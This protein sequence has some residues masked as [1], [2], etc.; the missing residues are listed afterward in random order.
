MGTSY[1]LARTAPLGAPVPTRRKRELER[2]VVVAEDPTLWST[3][4]E[5]DGAVSVVKCVDFCRSGASQKAT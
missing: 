2:F 4:A 3:I 5:N 1:N